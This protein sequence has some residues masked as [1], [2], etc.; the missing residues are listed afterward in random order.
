MLFRL[1]IAVFTTFL[2]FLGNWLT[3]A[4][5][6]EP[7]IESIQPGVM[8]LGETQSFTIVGEGLG[9]LYD[10]V[11]YSP[12][13]ACTEVVSKSDFEAV[14]KIRAELDSVAT[15]IP[16][17]LLTR[18]GF[19]NLR[20]LRLTNLPVMGEPQR[21]KKDAV[22]SL[23]EDF[24]LA[25]YGTLE[26]GDHD[27][28][29][30]FLHP[31][32]TCT[33][34]VEAV[35][36]GGPL[37]D[38]VLKVYS[39]SG[40]LIETV[41]DSLL[42]RQDPVL[43]FVA[44]EPGNYVIEI[45]ETNYGGSS[46]SHYLLF[47]GSFPKPSVVYPAG[48]P[49]DLALTVKLLEHELTSMGSFTIDQLTERGDHWFPLHLNNASG[50]TP[51]SIPL[52]VSPFE[53]V[54]ESE[55]C[56][57]LKQAASAISELPI[58]F[59]G[60]LEKPGDVDYFAFQAKRG[61]MVRLQAFAQAVGS[62]IDSR[63][64]V[65]DSSQNTVASNDDWS[66]HDSQL[67]FMPQNDG[68]Y[69]LC[70]TDKLLAGNSLGVYRVEAT[71]VSP[72][73]TA[74]LP[75][76]DRLSQAGQTIAI[77]QGN[78]SLV[79]LAVQREYVRGPALIE[80]PDTPS[81]IDI[82]RV[83]VPEDCF[84]YPLVVSADES[85]DV[86]GQLTPVLV[87]QTTETSEIRGG[88]AQA[89]DLV[90]GSADTLFYGVTVNELAIAVVDP[91]PFSIEL[92]QPKVQLAAGG[93]IKLKV[94]ATRKEGFTAPLNVYFPFLPPWVVCEPML[95]IPAG[96][97]TAT[98]EFTA[99]FSATPRTWPLVAVA[100]IDV[101]DSSTDWI[102]LQGRQVASQIVSLAI[103]STP[104][105]G[106][107]QPLASE[108]GKTIIASFQFQARASIPEEL[109]VT[110]EGLPNRV[111]AEPVTVASNK[112]SVEFQINVADDAPL[113]TFDSL[114]C[115]MQ[116]TLEGQPVS[117]IVAVGTKLQIAAPGRLARSPSGALLSPLEALR[118]A[119]Q[120]KNNESETSTTV[121]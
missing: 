68:V 78:R 50:L 35:R 97:S 63:I 49:A 6:V 101:K 55:T 76:N 120:Q 106:E 96:E 85:A 98:H 110:L 115:R 15:S 117:Y 119:S 95:V 69:F 48:G 32:Q 16:F 108:Q 27:R 58:A 65:F 83:E 30:V 111:H 118:A 22:V 66:S 103:G 73:L 99:N 23:P 53:N 100:E 81:G 14:V 4:F 86:Q 56:D 33:A 54:L 9:S 25:I 31:K 11:F 93:S 87:S 91:L 8:T 75:R 121:P 57:S 92:E 42:Y 37:L 21:D 20:T 60:I 113:G 89:I 5:A 2:A 46:D 94:T 61:E 82:P 116:G 19:S 26:R 18:D 29:S 62:A 84:W 59:N 109:L 104:L 105:S 114:R 7:K 102:A 51:T 90:A 34:I 52:R 40:E 74:F 45:H 41:D 36:L 3:S 80:V 79:K 112:G 67:D 88:F 71:L 10:I 1:S 39:P 64:T 12:K 13:I 77:P 107:F 24:R 72:A 43:T 70:V 38:T 28:Y 17:R 47:V 44:T